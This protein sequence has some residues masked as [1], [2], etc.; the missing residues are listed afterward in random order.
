M[1]RTWI[2]WMVILASLVLLSAGLFSCQPDDVECDGEDHRP[3]PPAAANA[4]HEAYR[5]YI[6]ANE[7]LEGYYDGDFNKGLNGRNAQLA[8]FYA[9]ADHANA[10]QVSECEGQITTHEE[11]I[12]D[13]D[14]A[15]PSVDCG[16]A[17][18]SDNPCHDYYTELLTYRLR[19][20]PGT[21]ASDGTTS[22]DAAVDAHMAKA[23]YA[24][25]DEQSSVCGGI[26]YYQDANNAGT[27]YR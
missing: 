21:F 19:C 13:E 11:T 8:Y 9:L 10:S 3:Q 15:A 22:Y 17:P 2:G 7:C 1:D 18:D 25:A 6:R 20:E 27:C 5:L 12:A 4:C 26:A 16:P 24:G 23:D 14:C